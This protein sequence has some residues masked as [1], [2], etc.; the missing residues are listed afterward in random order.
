[1]STKLAFYSA[2]QFRPNQLREEGVNVGLIVGI[3]DEPQLEMRLSKTN[4]RLKQ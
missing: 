4:E 1:V 3:D 2:I